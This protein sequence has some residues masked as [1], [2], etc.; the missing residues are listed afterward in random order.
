MRRRRTWP[1]LRPPARGPP[2]A[3][4]AGGC[5]SCHCF[6][7]GSTTR[8]P[9]PRTKQEDVVSVQPNNNAE[10]WGGDA[11]E[12]DGLAQLLLRSYDDATL[13][14]RQQQQRRQLLPPQRGRSWAAKSQEMVE[15]DSRIT[16]CST[17]PSQ[18]SLLPQV[19][20]E[21]L[22]RAPRR[23]FRLRANYALLL[24]L[25]LLPAGDESRADST[26]GEAVS[27]GPSSSTLPCISSVL[28]GNFISKAALTA[29]QHCL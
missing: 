9:S 19:R 15:S 13:R 28:L 14:W 4:P 1:R 5:S 25:K 6:N 23:L 8:R 26:R 20:C 17:R 3:A 10:W 12:I 11:A 29:A 24:L 7:A 2:R 21:I 22:V 18:V 27:R 16:L